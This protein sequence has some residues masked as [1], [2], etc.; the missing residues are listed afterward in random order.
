MPE[1]SSPTASRRI[2]PVSLTP[3]GKSLPDRAAR[4]LVIAVFGS[5]AKVGVTTIATALAH[6]LRSVGGDDVV[7]AEID[8]RVVRARSGLMTRARGPDAPRRAARG[9]PTPPE[10]P[11]DSADRLTIPGANAALVRQADG[12]WT[13]AM[14][15]PRTP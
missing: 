15:R 7:L 10:L 13:L 12:V 6:A 4:G 11:A 9:R 5:R 14:T 8:P 2:T 3:S 1:R